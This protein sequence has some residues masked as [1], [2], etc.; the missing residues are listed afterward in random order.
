MLLLA[1]TILV[2]AG[3]DLGRSTTEIA[4]PVG[5]PPESATAVAG[6]EAELAATD[7]AA[8]DAMA[9]TDDA[10][11]ADAA[12]PGRA[13]P[14]PDDPGETD[15]GIDGLVESF[16]GS[17]TERIVTFA[18]M[19]DLVAAIIEDFEEFTGHTLSIPVPLGRGNLGDDTQAVASN[20][21]S[22]AE[23]ICEVIIDE[24]IERR[25]SRIGALFAHLS[26]EIWHC[27]QLDVAPSA[28]EDAE[29]WI[30]EGQ[31]AWVDHAY[32]GATRAGD[33]E[34]WLGG[35]AQPPWSRAY[36]EA[37]LYAVAAQRGVDVWPTMLRM[38]DEPREEALA[39]LFET[40]PLD[41]LLL[42]AQARALWDP[43]DVWNLRGSTPPADIVAIP[44]DGV[45]FTVDAAA[46]GTMA[47]KID[48]SAG[49][50]ILQVE[51]V[52]GSAGAV[53][54]AGSVDS[55][56]LVVGES[57]DFCLLPDGCPCPTESAS[58]RAY[59]FGNP[60][61]GAVAAVSEAAGP[62]T[63]QFSYRTI[64]EDCRD[65]LVG[66]WSTTSYAQFT[67]IFEAMRRDGQAPDCD[68]PYHIEFREDGTFSVDYSVT[69][70]IEDVSN[71]SEANFSGTY[72]SDADTFTI[73]NPVGTGESTVTVFGVTT[74]TDISD[75]LAGFPRSRVEYQINDN[76]L[77]YLFL[78]TAFV[79]MR[80]E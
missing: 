54:L 80:T 24:D 55:H 33:L 8:D 26:H 59:Q 62:V 35:G 21:G 61:V 7:E 31:A 47:S 49:D 4:E 72:E 9:E 27:F 2:L 68:G 63:V 13:T 28:F 22:L 10:D 16:Q 18:E 79:F 6:G 44:S 17:D 43:V 12:E 66:T 53:Q 36:D 74:T 60:G 71:F 19:H 14:S 37:P 73:L 70:S 38:V 69:C 67:S 5:F 23:P 20:V 40:T 51:L 25:D 3:C 50:E 45:T 32:G 65:G 46:F 77:T 1:T 30:I 58:S 41:A 75:D 64:E 34:S 56:R 48:V 76:T 52:S 39:M 15:G 11:E 42:S 29:E 57:V 78:D